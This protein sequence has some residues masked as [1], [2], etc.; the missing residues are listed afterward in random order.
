MYLKLSLKLSVLICLHC[1]FKAIYISNTISAS[2]KLFPPSSRCIKV[3]F[4]SLFLVYTFFIPL[5]V[6]ARLQTAC[7]QI[8]NRRS[9]LSHKWPHLLY[10]R[11]STLSRSNAVSA[12]YL[13]PSPSPHRK[14]PPSL[15]AQSPPP[16]PSFFQVAR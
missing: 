2:F 11:L 7:I 15:T 12:S 10:T 16:P 8:F 1:R 3:T 6:L 13:F 5:T 4:T 14:V 9:L